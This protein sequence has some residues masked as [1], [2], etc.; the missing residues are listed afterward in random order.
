L[1][2]LPKEIYKLILLFVDH[3]SLFAC[4]LCNK[5]FNEIINDNN[6]WS[7]KIY[8]EFKELP[9]VT[10]GLHSQ[11][12]KI[13][14]KKGI[15]MKG[16]EMYIPIKDCIRKAY[17]QGNSYLVSYFYGCRQKGECYMDSSSE[18]PYD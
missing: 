9:K 3:D 2:I 17:E 12:V 8:L 10:W 11:Y 18:D 4:E 7:D 14:S 1:L 15:I 6:F 16:T 13:A 5:M